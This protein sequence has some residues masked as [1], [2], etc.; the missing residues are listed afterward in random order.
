M[1]APDKEEM[2]RVWNEVRHTLVKSQEYLDRLDKEETERLF[3]E[4]QH[5]SVKSQELFDLLDGDP[6]RIQYQRIQ[7]ADKMRKRQQQERESGSKGGKSRRWSKED[8]QRVQEALVALHRKRP[9]LSWTA[10]TN[11]IGEQLPRIIEGKPKVCGRT[12]RN[13][14]KWVRW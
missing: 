14:A 10:A 1:S 4:F 11:C 7:D 6:V 12:I 3:K 5:T 9:A 13:H 8:E 2:K